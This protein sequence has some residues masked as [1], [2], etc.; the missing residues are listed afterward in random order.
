MKLYVTPTSSYARLAFI[1]R[2]ENGLADK[3]EL[4]WTRRQRAWQ[5]KRSSA[6]RQFLRPYSCYEETNVIVPYLDNLV[7]RASSN[8]PAAWPIGSPAGFRRWRP[9][10]LTK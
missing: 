2:L 6:R 5:P 4:I 1:V 3:A 8:H 9:A 7:S 10:C